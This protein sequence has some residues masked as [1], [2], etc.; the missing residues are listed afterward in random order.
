MPGYRA[1]HWDALVAQ[2]RCPLH[3]E[4]PVVPGTPWCAACL[5]RRTGW[6]R[7]PAQ[8]CPQHPARR[9]KSGCTACGACLKAAR[10]RAQ[11][12]AG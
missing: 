8:Y 2:G 3:P 12:H 6:D 11:E 5:G 1:V 10:K 9:L 4:R 7:T